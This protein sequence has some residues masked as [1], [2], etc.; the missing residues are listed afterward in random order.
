[1]IP[2]PLTQI[3]LLHLSI[4]IRCP[5]TPSRSTWRLCIAI[6]CVRW[7]IGLDCPTDYHLPSSAKQQEGN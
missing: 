1:M 7:L 6:R 2:F 3:T 5:G 4:R